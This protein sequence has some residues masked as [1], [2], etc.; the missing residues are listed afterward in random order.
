MKKY[1]EY[2]ESRLNEDFEHE[3]YINE[4]VE[5]DEADIQKEFERYF[6]EHYWHW[7][8]HF[9]KICVYDVEETTLCGRKFKCH[10]NCKT[11]WRA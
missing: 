11:Y 10:T 6:D 8:D 3:D 4:M 9:L 2:W 1:I 7:M 5:V